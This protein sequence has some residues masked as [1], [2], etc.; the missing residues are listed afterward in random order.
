LPKRLQSHYVVRLTW[1]IGDVLGIDDAVGAIN[2]K[3]GPLFSSQ[4]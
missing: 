1:L 3:D 2:R 4:V